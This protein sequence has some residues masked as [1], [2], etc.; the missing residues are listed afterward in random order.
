MSIESII[1]TIDLEIARLQSARNLLSETPTT[2]RK[3]GRP[4]KTVT[5]IAEVASKKIRRSLS[6]E[7]RKKIADAQRLRWKRQKS[8]AKAA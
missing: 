4:V 1:E 3:V 2:K 6:P 7:A 8:A 5:G